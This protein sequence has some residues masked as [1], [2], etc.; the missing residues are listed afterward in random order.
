MQIIIFLMK[1]LNHKLIH[2]TLKLRKKEVDTLTKACKSVGLSSHIEI[3]I[4][5]C[6]LRDLKYQPTDYKLFQ[7]FH[8]KYSPKE[9]ILS[10]ST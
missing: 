1:I 2:I 10:S 8:K 7:I 4:E 3:S 9:T 5:W 6:N